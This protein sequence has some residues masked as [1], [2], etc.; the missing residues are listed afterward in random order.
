M[1][2]IVAPH[3]FIPDLRAL[4][5]VVLGGIRHDPLADPCE[6]LTNVRILVQVAGF[7][8]LRE[9]V[10]VGIALGEYVR[11]GSRLLLH[12]RRSIQHEALELGGGPSFVANRKNDGVVV[13]G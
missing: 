4:I 6:P 3:F 2:V 8:Q 10:H 5:Q 12:L 1:L 7:G 11:F 13:R 9:Q